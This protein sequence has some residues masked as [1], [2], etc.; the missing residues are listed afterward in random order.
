[1]R[2]RLLLL[3]AAAPLVSRAAPP[4]DAVSRLD[5]F[6]PGGAGGG[7]DQTGRALGAAI[8]ST[9]LV[10]QV[11]YENKGGKGGVPGLAE[12][13]QRHGR[14]PHAL[15]I[16]GM[17][18]VGSIAVNRP[19]ITLADVTPLARLTSDYMVLVVP[20]N[21]P[22]KTLGAVVAAMQ[23]DLGRVP[24]TGG[25]TG[26]VDHMLAGMIARQL[27]LDPAR[28]SYV[29]TS[30][31]AEALAA[32]SGGKAAV[33]ISSYSEFRGEIERQSVRPLAASSRHA[34]L[35]VPSL[36]EQGVY[37]E[38]ANWRAVFA[39]KGLDPAQTSWL[40]RLVE[41]A[42]DTPVWRSQL[43][44]NRWQPAWMGS[45]DFADSLVIEQA[46]AAAVTMM[47]KIQGR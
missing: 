4:P 23:Q 24:F 27:R 2:R 31:G 18:M 43:Q 5:L 14:N 34:L 26:G 39:P 20:A 3:G 28:L 16:G 6:I 47:L 13:V 8:E 44:G 11:V 38:L 36:H 42:V 35:G 33:A 29:P 25:S 30:S 19:P 46:M 45:K 1:M 40:A 22:F 17:V 32:L 7:W 37:T 12:F 15:L 10:K 21:S 9:G 41:R